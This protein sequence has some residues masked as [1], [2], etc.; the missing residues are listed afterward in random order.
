MIGIYKIENLIN[1]KIYIGQSIHIERRWSEHCFPSTKS[2]IS[3]AIKKYGKENFSFQILEE[4]FPEELDEKEIFYINKFNCI[5]PNGYNIKDYVDNGETVY[6]H[7]DKETFLQIVSDIKNSSIS[8]QEISEKYDI[9]KRLVYYINKGEIHRLS[10]EEY[11]LRKVMDYSKKEYHC[12]DCGKEITKGAE[13][14]KECA[15]KASRIVIRPTRDELK[16]LI[17]IKTFVELGRIYNVS[18][19]AI[20][21]W[22]KN[23]NLPSRRTDIKKISDDKWSLI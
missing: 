17:R 2:I 13:R 11:P 3:A 4:C 22:C 10:N 15:A 1:H 14:C 18:D 16:N 8:F 23:Y 21:K 9:T 12:V 6:S 20:K 5:A 19:N 7:Y